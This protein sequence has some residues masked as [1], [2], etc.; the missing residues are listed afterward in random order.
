MKIIHESGKEFHLSPGTTL[1]LTRYN[2]F[3]ND[4]GEQS[5][6]ISLPASNHNLELLGYPEQI[7]GKQKVKQRLDATIQSGVFSVNARQAIHSARRNESIETSFY[8]R[9]G[10]FYEKIKD[11][12]LEEIFQS[13]SIKFSNMYNT[14]S[15]MQGLLTGTDN[16]FAC[17]Q[18]MTDDYILNERDPS[19]LLDSGVHGFAKEH[20]TVERI[21][22]VDVTVPIGFYITPFI[23]VRHLLEEVFAYMGYSLG[24]SFLDDEPWRNMCFL[25]NNIDTIVDNRID[26][27]SIIPNISVTDLL[28]IIRKFNVEFAPDEQ[29]KVIHIVPFDTLANSAPAEDITANVDGEIEVQYNEYKQLKLASKLLFKKE[30]NPTETE[31]RYEIRP[32]GNLDDKNTSFASALKQHSHA[33]L[34]K[35]DGALVVDVV[36]GLILYQEVIGSLAYDF[37]GGG[38]LEVDERTFGDTITPLVYRGITYPYVGKGRS[39]YSKIVYSNEGVDDDIDSESDSNVLEP[40]LCLCYTDIADYRFC[41]GTLSNYSHTGAKLW[42]QSLMYNGEGGVFETFWRK[43]DTLLRNALQ[44]VNVELLLTEKQ[45]FSISTLQKVSMRGQNLFISMLDYVP[46]ASSVSAASLLTTRLQEPIDTAHTIDHYNL[47]R[48]YR[49]K[50]RRFTEDNQEISPEAGD[51]RFKHSEDITPFYPEPPTQQ[52][53]ETGGR[54]YERTYQLE[55]GTYTEIGGEVV[56]VEGTITV[57]L[58]PELAE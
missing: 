39:L 44:V 3:F 12:E 28:D 7:S 19:N 1:E 56:F 37:S 22:K 2:P 47:S 31:R 55:Y 34:R 27:T 24:A 40:M 32:T 21:D 30:Y 45:K 49:W 52:Q 33:Y 16:R 29:N 4:K 38:T 35:V 57:W 50:I 46:E 14:L 42:G 51:F 23:K 6:P 53:F 20:P 25:N 48:K 43:R 17:F 9:E 26:Y 8:L 15:F 10:A 54:F 36:K 13:I 58:E 18:V 5:I 11:V 41:I